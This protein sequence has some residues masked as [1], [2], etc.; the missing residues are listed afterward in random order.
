VHPVRERVA[1]WS[2]TIYSET[3][4]PGATCW[5]RRALLVV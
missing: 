4:K 1:A 3:R 5:V 2:T